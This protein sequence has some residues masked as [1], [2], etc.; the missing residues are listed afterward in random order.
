M[1][2]SFRRL[3]G[4]HSKYKIENQMVLAEIITLK[5]HQNYHRLLTILEARQVNK[6]E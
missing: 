3:N 5:I 6:V 1:R 4:F 2:T